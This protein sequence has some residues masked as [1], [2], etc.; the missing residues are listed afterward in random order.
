MAPDI[1]KLNSS[2]L[3]QLL[4]GCALLL[5]GIAFFFRIPEI[6][7]GFAEQ[8]HLLGAWYVHLSLYFVSIMLIGGGGKKIYSLRYG[9]DSEPDSSPD[10]EESAT[11][12][13]ES[14][15]ESSS[16]ASSTGSDSDAGAYQETDQNEK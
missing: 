13:P 1:R 12:S 10:S 8:Q 6:M 7:R 14:Y 2:E 16:G 11:S 9:A 15:P 3:F 5:M 4:W